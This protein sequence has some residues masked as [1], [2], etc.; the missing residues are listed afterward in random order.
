MHLVSTERKGK[1]LELGADRLADALLEL[2]GRDEFADDLVERMIATPQDNIGRFRSKLSA[3]QL[4]RP[5]VHWRQTAEYARE[6]ENL[7]EDLRAGVTDPRTGTELVVSF[8][9]ADS[10]IF[11]N[12]DDSNGDVGDMFR[13]D[14]RDLF[15]AYASRCAE[16]EWLG[17]LVFKVIQCDDYGAAHRIT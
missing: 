7:L 12:C 11:A 15:V 8:Y 1:L 4:G 14:A 13:Y 5:F 2:A 3:L 9:Q 6:L 17:D 16:K 10:V